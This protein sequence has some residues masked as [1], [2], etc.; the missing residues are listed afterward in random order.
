MHDGRYDRFPSILY[1]EP[2]PA[3]VQI[4]STPISSKPKIVDYD[5]NLIIFYKFQNHEKKIE[6]LLCLPHDRRT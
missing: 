6:I 4:M 3:K 2:F 1:A 5:Y